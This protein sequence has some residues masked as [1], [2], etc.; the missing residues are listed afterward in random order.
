MRAQSFAIA[1]L[2]CARP[3]VHAELPTST[4]PVTDPKSL[5]SMADPAARSVPADCFRTHAA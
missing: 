1:A 5:V 2:L 4:R 3:I